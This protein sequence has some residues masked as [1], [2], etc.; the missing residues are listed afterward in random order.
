MKG[1]FNAQHEIDTGDLENGLLLLIGANVFTEIL[2]VSITCNI[3]SNQQIDAYLCAVVSGTGSGGT[4]VAVSSTETS[5]S[6][7]AVLGGPFSSIPTLSAPLWREAH[8]AL[9]GWHY[10]PT[11]EERLSGAAGGVVGVMLFSLPL[12]INVI[13]RA[14]WRERGG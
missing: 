13:V 4:S 5:T 1:V 9:S 8:N 10:T 7:N 2:S 11:E 12:P 14:T 6:A 3:A